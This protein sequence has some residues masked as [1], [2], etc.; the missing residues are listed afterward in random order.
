M[1]VSE[2]ALLGI[3]AMLNFCILFQLTSIRTLLDEKN[4]K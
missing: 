4:K 2:I 3:L 1:F